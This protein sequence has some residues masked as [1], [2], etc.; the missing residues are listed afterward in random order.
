[1]GEIGRSGESEEEQ[2]REVRKKGLQAVFFSVVFA[3]V[4]A[5][6]V[7][8]EL[9]NREKGGGEG[10]FRFPFLLGA[11]LDLAKSKSGWATLQQDVPSFILLQPPVP[12]AIRVL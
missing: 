10:A 7:C 11:E 5:L 1:V 12:L 6:S 9:A 8:S 4:V 2:A 3:I